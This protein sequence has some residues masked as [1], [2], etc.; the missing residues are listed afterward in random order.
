MPNTF[1]AKQIT[2]IVSIVVLYI[3]ATTLYGVWMRRY[4][5]N[6]E[7]F[8]T[9]GKMPTLL[10]GV[11]MV[12]EFI[13][14]SATVGTAQT[15]FSAGMA[16]AWNM[17]TLAIGF[18]LFGRFLA[19]KF[20]EIG[21][22][23]ISGAVA[24]KYGQGTRLVTSIIMIY[25]LLTVNVALYVGGA[26]AVSSVLNISITAAAVITAIVTTV[27]VSAG[28]LR[29]V[30]YVNLIH[31]FFKYVGVA[32]VIVVGLQLAG[33]YNN[34]SNGLQP[35]YFTPVGKVGI[36]TIVAWT[37]ANIGAVFSTQMIIQALAGTKQVKDARKASY[38]AAILI[39][40]IS[41]MASFVGIEARYVFPN[42][43]DVMAFPIFLQHMSPWLA[44]IV[45]IGIVAT[46]FANVSATTLGVTA[47]VMKDFY[48]PYLKPNE[49]KHL[50]ISRVISII[51]GL[52]PIPFVLFVPGILK[53][54]FFARALRASISVIAVCGFF[55]P[56]FSSGIG[57]SL[58]LI[59]AAL[60]ASAWFFMGNPL[61]IDSTYVAI[62]LPLIVM[63]ID[64]IVHK[65][66]KEAVDT[67][68]A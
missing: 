16:A 18:L 53:T 26:A 11:L 23:T 65:K 21:D 31:F 43:K 33:G 46:V 47:L 56:F 40:P 20:R 1:G 36:S 42:I 17:A 22:Y 8:M 14:T 25:A 29:S 68:Q 60:G 24:R 50:I 38:I 45:T 4:T 13:G 34:I 58:G 12:S 41:V 66:N 67:Y 54:M 51:V 62:L 35:Y 44:G 59:I 28:G 57:A 52:L 30:A 48:V 49:D 39:I 15:A 5:K 32:I 9:G 64:H 10:I 55:L 7:Q 3:L 37:V 2:I 27:Y 63:L 19:P 6:N 61:G